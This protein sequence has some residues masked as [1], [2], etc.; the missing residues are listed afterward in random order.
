MITHVCLHLCCK[1][2]N[3]DAICVIMCQCYDGGLAQ[4]SHKPTWH[5]ATSQSDFRRSHEV[6]SFLWMHAYMSTTGQQWHSFRKQFPQCNSSMVWAQRWPYITSG[7][8]KLHWSDIKPKYAVHAAIMCNHPWP[9][10]TAHGAKVSANFCSRD[11]NIEIANQPTANSCEV[12]HPH[13]STT[14][15]LVWHR[16]SS[17]R[18]DEEL[19]LTAA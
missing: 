9:K 12:Q 18:S 7:Q 15:Y 3:N 19:H 4:F 16:D 8:C 6:V 5:Q 11:M 14:F 1:V 17:Q 10:A 13:R 2:E